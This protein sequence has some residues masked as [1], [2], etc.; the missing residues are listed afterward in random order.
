MTLLQT[1]IINLDGMYRGMY[2]KKNLTGD[3]ENIRDKMVNG[4]YE[5][6]VGNDK[7]DFTPTHYESYLQIYKTPVEAIRA[8]RTYIA[9][10][11]RENRGENLSRTEQAEFDKLSK[12]EKLALDFDN[13]HNYMLEKDSYKQQ[14]ID[15]AL[16]LRK[17]EQAGGAE[18]G[19]FDTNNSS[20]G[21][22]L[23]LILEKI[24]GGMSN[25]FLKEENA[26]GGIAREDVPILPKMKEWL[27]NEMDRS[28]SQKEDEME[29]LIRGLK[30][31]INN[32]NEQ[33]IM[34]DLQELLEKNWMDRIFKQNASE[35]KMALG[36]MFADTS[37]AQIMGDV[38]S[39][40][41]Q[42]LVRI[43]NKV[44]QEAVP[45]IQNNI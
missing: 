4:K 25:R 21:I 1:A 33:S 17:K 45:Q 27:D 37:L 41:R 29:M 18:S 8:Y 9:L 35:T 26:E 16:D 2:N 44:L 14:D 19:M 10:K 31:S 23:S 5:I 39:R 38:Q 6:N 40:F 20:S 15:Y 42:R 13:S 36:S 24:F 43:I 3:L 32:P 34:T 30:R 7:A 28:L 12:I 11:D 22:Y